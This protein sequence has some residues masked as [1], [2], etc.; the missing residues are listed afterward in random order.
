MPISAVCSVSLSLLGTPVVVQVLG[1]GAEG[2]AAGVERAWR[3]CVADA[4][5]GVEPHP[6]TA[7][8]D[9]DPGVVAAAQSEGHLAGSDELSILDWLSSRLTLEAIESRLGQLWMLH[10]SAVAD[11]AT[12]SAIVLV[13]PSGTGKT[14]AA[15][16]LG[17]H[18]GY[19][20]DE[21]AAIAADGT[22]LPYPKPLSVLV[23]GHRPKR[24][25]SP[26][27]L[28]LLPTPTTARVAAVVLLD[29][30]REPTA[31]EVTHVRTIEALPALAEQTSALKRLPRPLHLV[32][33]HLHAVGGL[34]RLTYSDAEDLPPVVGELLSAGPDRS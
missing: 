27:E 11:P 6:V 14:T 21:T 32:A 17:Q 8:L 9:E 18:F 26:D 31:P 24:Q 29:R 10:A 34:R 22:V 20:T 30:R 28:G 19:L 3:R 16:A 15:R 2:L 5:P 1:S 7:V 23:D 33:E 25:L 4:P 12:G 13:A